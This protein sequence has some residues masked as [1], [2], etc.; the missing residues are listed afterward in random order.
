MVVE[1]I[2]WFHPL[3]WWLG[4]RLVEER[5]RACDEEVLRL[6][7]PPV[8]YAE[9]ILK[10]CEFCVASPL[11]CVSG[12][13]GADLKQRMVRIMT[14]R[15][16]DKLGFLKKLLLVAMGTGAVTIPVVTG[17]IKAP[18]ATA[19]TTPA[20]SN[21]ADPQQVYHVGGDVSAPKL[22]Y[23]PD[24]VFTE[25]ARRAKYQGACVISTVVDALGNPT[26]VQVARHLGMGLDKKAVEAVKQYRFTPAKRL[27]NP[28]AVKVNIEV[29][30][31]LY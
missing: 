14:Q 11:A 10:T 28:V 24:P 6:G 1:A 2:F 4:T 13:T 22:V 27:G 23:A 15:S 9:S 20:S 18:V 21:F 26:R 29:N 3:V 31:R 12:V 8:I 5:E 16:V 7:N 25:K 30:F 19:Q 17:L